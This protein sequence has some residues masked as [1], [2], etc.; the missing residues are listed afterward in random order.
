[1]LASLDNLLFGGTMIILQ[2]VTAILIMLISIVQLLLVVAS[3]I[4][5]ILNN[6]CS[7]AIDYLFS[8]WNK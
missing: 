1:M 5:G 6:Y 8:M 7:R 3:S 4:A 2:Y